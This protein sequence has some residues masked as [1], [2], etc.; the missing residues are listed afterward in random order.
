MILY[1]SSTYPLV[2]TGDDRFYA[3][4]SDTYRLSIAFLFDACGQVSHVMIGGEPYHPVEVAPPSDNDAGLWP[5]FEG[6]YKDPTNYNLDE[7]LRMKLWDG[8]L[9]FAEEDEEVPGR[10]ISSRCFSSDLGLI[11]FKD[12][13]THPLQTLVWGKAT[14]YNPIDET[15]F[16]PNRVIRYLVEVPVGS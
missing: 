7:I 10:A 5:A 6:L 9:F 15:T 4:L 2:S 12:S 3:Q 1:H 13:N 11:E 16:H 14:L 8:V